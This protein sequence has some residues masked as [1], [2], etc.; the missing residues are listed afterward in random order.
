MGADDDTVTG[1]KDRWL[2]IPG[3]ENFFDWCMRRNRIAGFLARSELQ[4]RPCLIV[5]WKNPV[6]NPEEARRLSRR[7]EDLLVPNRIS[8]LSARPDVLMRDLHR[9]KLPRAFVYHVGVR[10]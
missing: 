8:A 7:K 3:G 9:R 2:W 4:K 1:L 10:Q 6:R 5:Q